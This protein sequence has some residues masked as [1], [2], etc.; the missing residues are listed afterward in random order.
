MNTT[1][2]PDAGKRWHSRSMRVFA[3]ALALSGCTQAQMQ[4]QQ[5]SPA[6]TVTIVNRAAFAGQRQKVGFYAYLNADCSSQ[7]YAVVRAEVLPTHGTVETVNGQGFTQYPA[8]NQRYQ[9]NLVK[10]PLVE[11]F[12]TSVPGYRGTDEFVLRT[13]FPGG[14]ARTDKYSISVE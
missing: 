5:P 14:I 9:C 10:A 13:V 11:V 3:V 1:D 12:Y 8:D 2:G 4:T 7:G 6:G